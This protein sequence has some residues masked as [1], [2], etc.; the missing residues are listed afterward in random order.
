MNE[1]ITKQVYPPSTLKHEIIWGRQSIA[2]F[3]DCTVDRFDTIAK[4]D[5]PIRRRAGCWVATKTEL[6]RWIMDTDET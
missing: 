1:T 2:N 5:A 3:L 4:S 6:T